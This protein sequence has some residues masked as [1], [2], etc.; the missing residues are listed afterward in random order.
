MGTR[1]NSLKQGKA[2]TVKDVIRFAAIPA[3]MP[4][5][6]RACP[7]CETKDTVCYLGQDYYGCSQCGA[8]WRECDTETKRYINI[9]YLND[10]YLPPRPAG[11]PPIILRTFIPNHIIG[12]VNL[13]RG[14]ITRGNE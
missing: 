2:L 7:F 11:G 5:W 6:K 10:G 3:N 14:T 1:Y 12:V 4:K 13:D 8:N 9:L